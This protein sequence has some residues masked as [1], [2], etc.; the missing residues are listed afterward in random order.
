M[1]IGCLQFAPQVGDVDNNLSRAD[2]I[3]SQAN[4]EGL[5]LLIL[6]ELAFSGYNFKSLHEIYPYLEPTGAGISSLWARTVALKYDCT[7]AVGY[8]EKA[9]VSHK[10]PTSPEYYNSLIV[11]NREGDTWAHYRK[12]HLYYTDESWALEGPEGFYKGYLP[13]VGKIALGICMDIN[14]YKFEAPWDE[15]EFSAHALEVAANVLIISMAWLTREDSNTFSTRPHEPDMETL[16]YWVKRME[17]LI[18]SESG[19]EVIV[20]FANRSG[21]EDDVVYAGTSAVLGIQNGEVTVYGVLGRGEKQLLVVDTSKPG[22]AKMVYRP[23]DEAQDSVDNSDDSLPSIPDDIDEESD[24]PEPDNSEVD[25]TN[26]SEPKTSGTN[27]PLDEVIEAELEM[28]RQPADVIHQQTVPSFNAELEDSM[29]TSWLSSQPLPREIMAQIRSHSVSRSGNSAQNLDENHNASEDLKSDYSLTDVDSE[30]ITE[31][32]SLVKAFKSP[33]YMRDEA[34]TRPL[35]T[36]SRDSSRSRNRTASSKEPT[37]RAHSR[38]QFHRQKS[39]H[40][41]QPI[42]AASPKRSQSRNNQSVQADDLA[43]RDTRSRGR[44]SPDLEKIGADLMVFEEGNTKGP[45]RDSLLCHVDNDDYVVLQTV[46]KDGRSGGHIRS[47][48]EKSNSRPSSNTPSRSTSRRHDNPSHEDGRSHSRRTG[49]N[50]PYDSARAS[51][52][53]EA[54]SGSRSRQHVDGGHYTSTPRSIREKSSL[55]QMTSVVTSP[56]SRQEAIKN[57]RADIQ[58]HSPTRIVEHQ[59]V[60]PVQHSKYRKERSRRALRE[61]SKS[62]SLIPGLFSPKDMADSSP[63]IFSPANHEPGNPR[64]GH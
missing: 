17:P 3:L 7:V 49:R 44:A 51:E 16:T 33:S 19:D 45:K 26:L 27:G 43:N 59:A 46:R 58:S 61:E 62:P 54:D 25:D 13:G 5:D 48:S 50:D 53:R 38:S 52:Y 8:P 64:H 23:E 28:D 57:L 37:E 10:W 24:M 31:F 40:Q 60:V 15:F 9:D 36:I 39:L 30:P 20:V 63:S 18:R 56:R 6:P 41:E 12:T 14:P 1:K 21:I 11:V 2:K 55:S 22:Y 4:P 47:A 29:I 42:G 35:P 34:V 32:S